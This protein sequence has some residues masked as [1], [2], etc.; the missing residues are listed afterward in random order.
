M[1]L[2]HNLEMPR[3]MA[4]MV[5]WQQFPPTLAACLIDAHTLNCPQQK[6]GHDPLFENCYSRLTNNIPKLVSVII[7]FL[8]YT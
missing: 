4:I 5:T 1:T 7:A 6:L 2:L 8:Y 3:V